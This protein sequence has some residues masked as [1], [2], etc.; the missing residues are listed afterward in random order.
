MRPTRRQL[1]KWGDKLVETVLGRAASS[2]PGRPLR[3][4]AI[5][6]IRAHGLASAHSGGFV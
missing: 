3:G 5:D 1:L 2:S 6:W 4:A